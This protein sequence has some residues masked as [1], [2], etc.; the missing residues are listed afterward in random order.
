MKYI[1]T[2]VFIYAIENHP[3]YGL[4]CKKILLD[5]ESKRLKVVASVFVLVEVIGVL[6][7]INRILR[8]D[9]KDTLN[10]SKNIDAILSLPITWTDLNS[11]IIRRAAELFYNVTGVDHIHVSTMEVNSVTEILSADIELD[12]IKTLA[13]VD[14]LDYV[15]AEKLF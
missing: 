6:D 11:L 8:K 1:D 15:E 5:I 2:N 9:R 13:R 12:K 7:K 4:S 3:K 14:P 10:V